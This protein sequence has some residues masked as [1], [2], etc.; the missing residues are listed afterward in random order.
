M[1]DADGQQT[2]RRNRDKGASAIE[3]LILLASTLDEEKQNELFNDD[4]VVR[5][6]SAILVNPTK[7]TE[8]KPDA[9]YRRI[10]AMRRSPPMRRLESDITSIVN[11]EAERMR[12]DGQDVDLID[13]QD[14]RKSVTEINITPRGKR[15]LKRM[16]ELNRDYSRALRKVKEQ[17]AVPDLRRVEIASKLA[18]ILVKYCDEQLPKLLGPVVAQLAAANSFAPSLQLLQHIHDVSSLAQTNTSN[19]RETGRLKAGK[20]QR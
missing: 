15:L 20:K 11:V 19:S 10:D 17:A 2:W 4:R 1:D 8:I 13:F 9:Y 12:A 3:D 7:R 5:L 16:D 14:L 18:I 6:F